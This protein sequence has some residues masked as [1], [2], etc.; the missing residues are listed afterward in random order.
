MKHLL[1]VCISTS[2]MSIALNHIE[3]VEDICMDMG[4]SFKDRKNARYIRCKCKKYPYTKWQPVNGDLRQQ[5][6]STQSPVHTH[7]NGQ[8]QRRLTFKRSDSRKL[9]YS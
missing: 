2:H 7:Q 9:I 3:E 8:R 5:G 6:S 1:P 4:I